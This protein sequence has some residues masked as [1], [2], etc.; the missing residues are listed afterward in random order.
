ME[1]RGWEPHQRLIF[2]AT[3]AGGMTGFMGCLINFLKGDRS[4]PLPLDVSSD[5][6][7]FLNLNRNLF[8]SKWKRTHLFFRRKVYHLPIV[9]WSATE[10]H[11]TPT[12]TGVGWPWHA[13]GM[14]PLIELYRN[15]LSAWSNKEMFKSQYMLR[16]LS[17]PFTV[18]FWIIGRCVW[19]VLNDSTLCFHKCLRT[20]QLS[21]INK[22]LHLEV[23]F[24]YT[25]TFISISGFFHVIL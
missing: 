25:P 17:I 5:K 14:K 9:I 3:L 18:L 6:R 8:Y 7:S 21:R 20:N 12:T 2:Y 19:V 10:S 22:V 24:P 11:F 16:F 23:L 15:Q 13:A 1:S 4:S